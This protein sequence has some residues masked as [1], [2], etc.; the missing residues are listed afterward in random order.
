MFLYSYLAD[1]CQYSV[2]EGGLLPTA[3]GLPT[4]LWYFALWLQCSCA[5]YPYDQYLEKKAGL[6]SCLRAARFGPLSTIE[7][8]VVA[9]VG[10][11]FPL[12]IESYSAST[13]DNTVGAN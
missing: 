10:N 3:P 7:F 2:L 8:G 4:I 1:V 9:P 11:H 5:C 6:P 13:T 12:T